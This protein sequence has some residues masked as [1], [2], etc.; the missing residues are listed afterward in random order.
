MDAFEKP[1]CAKCGE[2]LD[3]SGALDP[4]GAKPIYMH[5][6]CAF[7]VREEIRAEDRRRKQ[8]LADAAP[9]LLAACKRLIDAPHQEHFSSRLND[10]EMADIEAI[11]RAIAKAEGGAA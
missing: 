10:D 11:K 4:R 9:D 3:E 1:T 2:H 5:H 6:G 7:T 8:S